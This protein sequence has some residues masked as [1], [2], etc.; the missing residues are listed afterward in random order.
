MPSEAPS[1]RAPIALQREVPESRVLTRRLAMSWGVLMR[2]E[3]ETARVALEQNER[4]L[5]RGRDV[6]HC[7]SVLNCRCLRLPEVWALPLPACS[8]RG[9]ANPYTGALRMT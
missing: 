6:L 1:S 8:G 9:G 4:P 2:S 3:L 5:G 7:S